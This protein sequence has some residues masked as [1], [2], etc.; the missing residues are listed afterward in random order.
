MVDSLILDSFK[1]KYLKYLI[2]NAI[3]SFSK[4]TLFLHL[5]PENCGKISEFDVV[6]RQ[7]V[8]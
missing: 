7:L 5:E 8:A 1:K 3:F 6:I 4:R 2:L